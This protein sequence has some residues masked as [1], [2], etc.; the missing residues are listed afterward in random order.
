[1][2]A[3]LLGLL[4]RST[5]CSPRICVRC[6]RITERLSPKQRGEILAGRDAKCERRR[7]GGHL[8]RIASGAAS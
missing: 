6:D 2:I 1:M 5:P 4:S 3:V 8:D 7:C